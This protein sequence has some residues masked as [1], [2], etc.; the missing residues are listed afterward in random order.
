[1][2]FENSDYGALKV[3]F[4]ISKLSDARHQSEARTGLVRV[5][6]SIAYGLATSQE[7][8]VSFCATE[9]FKA[10]SGCLDYLTHESRFAGVPFLNRKAA[11]LGRVLDGRL[12]N[13]NA[14]VEG[15]P[16]LDLLREPKRPTSFFKGLKLHR[17][18]ERRLLHYA[19]RALGNRL[20]QLDPRWLTRADVFHSPFYPLPQQ[21]RDV[22]KFL[23]VHDLIPILY[24]QFCVPSQVQF[25]NEILHSIGPEDWVV[26][27]SEATKNDLCNHAPID[28]AR[29]FVTLLAAAPELFYPCADPEK[30]ARVRIKYDIPDGPYILSLN[31]LEP[32]KNVGHVV[33]CFAR[34]VQEENIQDLRLVLVGAKGWLYD[35]ILET[36]SVY[37]SLADRIIVTGYVADEDLAALYSAA[38]AF[39]FPSFCEGFGLPPLEAMQCG[40][41]VITS[42]TSSLPEVVGDAGVML[43]PE[44]ADGLCHS[45]LQIYRS[46]SLREAMSRRSVVRAREFSWR[47]CTQETV[48]AYNV[49]LS[50]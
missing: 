33:Q 46:A 25:A 41:P 38:L 40:T 49:A 22:Q 14:E 16:F 28:P 29:V 34:L 4:D 36:I 20:Q 37:D 12:K 21:V 27:V 15:R 9:S 10:L 3:I 13:A 35:G 7:C 24:P 31:T 17:R 11:T 2:P 44:D 1:M 19:F 30:I 23:T 45:I 39:I 18:A 32:R 26:C 6:E 42:N 48:A 47:K 43:D 5:V 50:A 8:E